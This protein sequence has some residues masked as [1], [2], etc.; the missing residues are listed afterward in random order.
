MGA[1]QIARAVGD[2]QWL[3]DVASPLQE[4][5]RKLF[6]SAGRGGREAK[7]FLHGSALGHPLHPALIEL[8]VG[9]WTLAAIFDA[10]E[11]ADGRQRGRIADKA[12]GV[13]LIGA[14]A[15]AVA[16]ITDWS[17]TDGR[18]KRIGLAHGAMNL[19]ATGLYVLSLLLRR[20]SRSAG[21]GV[22]MMA[23]GLAMSSA[24]LGGHL[25][26]GEQI[27]VDHTATA[28]QGKPEQYVAVLDA[29]ELAENK[30]TRVTAEGVAVL[31]VKQGEKIFA[32][33]ETCSHLGGPLSKGKLE[34]D[35]IRCPWHGSRFCLTDGHVLDGPAVFPERVFDVRVREGQI[36]VRARQEQ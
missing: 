25:T 21:I 33:T 2:Q 32:L 27:G 36:E 35:S 23:F 16:G 18:A 12:I 6:E 31:L 20:N 13:G 22:G 24:F 5:I 26:Y 30:P 29:S 8:P 11:L 10:I 15:A 28:D 34:G 7:K 9:A 1:E 4:A 3:D 19:T 14:A 17:E